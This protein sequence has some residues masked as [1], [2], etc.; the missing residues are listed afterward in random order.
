MFVYLQVDLNSIFSYF[1][2][3]DIHWHS[4]MQ[5]VLVG[6]VSMLRTSI[7]LMK[8]IIIFFAFVLQTNL[9]WMTKGPGDEIYSFVMES[10][11]EDTLTRCFFKYTIY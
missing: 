6:K 8:L 4:A 2:S 3:R 1:C 5:Y 7:C 10:L 11:K 9:F